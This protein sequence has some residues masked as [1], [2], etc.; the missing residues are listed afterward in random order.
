M[1]IRPCVRWRR[2]S[3]NLVAARPHAVSL[4]TTSDNLNSGLYSAATG[5]ARRPPAKVPTNVRRLIM[6]SRWLQSESASRSL[7]HL[8]LHPDP[9]PVQLDELP[10]Q[11]QPEPGSLDLLVRR[12]HLP[13]LLEDRLLILW[14][15]A[16]ARVGDGDL[17]HA[18][19]HRGAHV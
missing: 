12:A 14:R 16:H 17:G 4:A 15:D 18:V 8:A 13:E 1:L 2:T 7:A 5:V 6:R 11:G 19:V 10:G 9:A 3:A